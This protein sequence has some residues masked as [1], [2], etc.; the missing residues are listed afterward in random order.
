MSSAFKIPNELKQKEYTH[1]VKR[2]L[3]LHCEERIA[4]QIERSKISGYEYPGENARPESS[5]SIAASWSLTY[6]VAFFANDLQSRWKLHN[7]VENGL[8]AVIGEKIR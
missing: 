2:S 1:N 7:A 4:E 6:H 8:A 3:A 5:S